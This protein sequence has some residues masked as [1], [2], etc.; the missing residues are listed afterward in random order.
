MRGEVERLQ[1]SLAKSESRNAELERALRVLTAGESQ[2]Q[3]VQPTVGSPRT[4]RPTQSPRSVA[5]LREGRGV[6]RV[7]ARSNVVCVQCYRYRYY[8]NSILLSCLKKNFP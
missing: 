5:T 8:R 1:A 3:A 6:Y 2:K 4:S 7:P